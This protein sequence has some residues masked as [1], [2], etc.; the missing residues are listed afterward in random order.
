MT[1]ILLA[2]L[3]LLGGSSEAA[4]DVVLRISTE[5]QQ[6]WVGQRVRLN[7][8]VLGADGW[9]QIPDLPTVEVPGAYLYAVLGLDGDG[10]VNAGDLDLLLANWGDAL[11][12]SPIDAD[13]SGT[14]DAGDLAIVQANWGQGTAPGVV[15]E[16]GSLALLGL[17]GLALL[18]R[19]RNA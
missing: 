19:R 5:P 8:E 18:R 15:P 7:I 12:G 16:P 6:A 13:G 17:G 4:E 10:E 1:I 2:V 9:A 14:I 11:V 3:V